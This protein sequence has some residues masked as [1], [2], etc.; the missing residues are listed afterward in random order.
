MNIFYGSN[1]KF[2]DTA[3]YMSDDQEKWTSG[4]Y[5]LDR[6]LQLSNNTL[7]LKCTLKSQTIFFPGFLSRL[8]LRIGC[9]YSW[10]SKF[11]RFLIDQI[12]LRKK[13]AFN[14]SAAPIGNKKSVYHWCR[15]LNVS[16]K[17]TIISDTITG[18]GVE[19]KK[20]FPLKNKQAV[21]VVKKVNEIQ[22]M[23]THQL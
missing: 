21:H 2:Q 15:E 7:S 4:G 16:G 3:I 1:H 6:D 8:L 17:K 18:P 23:C 11:L 19:A 13:S 14:Q 10:S 12:R 9:K 22:F 20:D 5:S